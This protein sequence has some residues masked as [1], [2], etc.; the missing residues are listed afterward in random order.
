MTQSVGWYRNANHPGV[1]SN[2]NDLTQL[3]RHGDTS[4][5]CSQ[6]GAAGAVDALGFGGEMGYDDRP[7]S[8]AASIF[9]AASSCICGSTCE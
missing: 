4:F 8:R 7:F 5:L 6:N 1:L 3:A 2:G 9:E